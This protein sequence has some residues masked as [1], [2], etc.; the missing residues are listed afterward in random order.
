VW[1]KKVYIDDQVFAIAY[2]GKFVEEIEY[3]LPYHA[4]DESSIFMILLRY[5]F[6]FI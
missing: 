1:G 3:D 5:N 6:R 4:G 2:I